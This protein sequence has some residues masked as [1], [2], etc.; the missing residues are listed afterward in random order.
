MEEELPEESIIMLLRSLGRIQ[1]PVVNCGV[2]PSPLF[3]V[4]YWYFFDQGDVGEQ[5]QRQVNA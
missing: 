1:H 5:Q 3:P 4:R 2:G